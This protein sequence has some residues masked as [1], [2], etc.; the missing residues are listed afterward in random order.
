MCPA[1]NPDSQQKRNREFMHFKRERQG[2]KKY[3]L[4]ATPTFFLPMCEPNLYIVW[5][6]LLISQFSHKQLA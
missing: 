4:M 5:S 1:E 3:M 2:R 6:N